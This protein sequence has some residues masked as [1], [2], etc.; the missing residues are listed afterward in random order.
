MT[1][2]PTI[3]IVDYGMGNR[4]SVQKAFERIGADVAITD[5]RDYILEADG[6]VIVGVGAFPEAMRRLKERGLDK[7][8]RERYDRRWPILGICLGL[9]MFFKYSEEHEGA[10]GFG[11][12]DGTIRKLP[13]GGHKVPHIGW[14]QVQWRPD[15]RLRAGVSEE[16]SVFYHLH[17]FA[18]Y[19][20]MDG[21]D[22]FSRPDVAGK[23]T[24]SCE[25]VTAVEE[26]PLYGVQF[27]PE[28]S[29]DQGLRLLENFVEICR[30]RRRER[31]PAVL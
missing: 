8:L 17:S 3:A 25:F 7:V 13:S 10:E 5:D 24:Y 22:F 4:R 27:H 29:S 12:L 19:D 1:P 31:E 23:T 2:S 21:D 20:G 14:N 15:S 30:E 28:K 6:A 16:D 9:Q 11:F 18:A 26:D